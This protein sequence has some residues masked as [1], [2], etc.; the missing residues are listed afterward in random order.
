MTGAGRRIKALALN[1]HGTINV[2]PQV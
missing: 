2:L 1:G